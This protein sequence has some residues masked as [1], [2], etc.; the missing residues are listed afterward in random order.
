MVLGMLPTG[1]EPA[2]HAEVQL[3]KLQLQPGSL[4]H[5]DA[6]DREKEWVGWKGFATS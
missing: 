3:W 5:Q 2:L 1:H 4:S 6:L